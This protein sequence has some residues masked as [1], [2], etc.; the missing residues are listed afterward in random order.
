MEAQKDPNALQEN[1]INFSPETEA[2]IEDISLDL[3][4]LEID[5]GEVLKEI[6]LNNR[7][8]QFMNENEYQSLFEDYINVKKSNIK[9][10]YA[11]PLYFIKKIIYFYNKETFLEPYFL[12]LKS[13]PNQTK[14]KKEK[15]ISFEARNIKDN[16]EACL[17]LDL[18][19]KKFNVMI[20]P[21]NKTFTVFFNVENN[22]INIPIS[23]FDKG[24]NEVTI[25]SSSKKLKFKGAVKIKNLN[26]VEQGKKKKENSFNN[27]SSGDK[28][29]HNESNTNS[30]Q[31]NNSSSKKGDKSSEF[32][33]KENTLISYDGKNNDNLNIIIKENNDNLLLE[34]NKEKIGGE[35][36]ESIANKTF[37]LMCNI[38][39]NRDIKVTTLN[40][41]NPDKINSFFNLNDENQINVFQIDTYIPK[42]SGKEIKKIYERFPNNFLFFEE[43]K[44]NDYTNYEIIGEVSQNIVNNAKQKIAQEFNYIHLINK[45]NNYPQKNDQ[46]FIALCKHFGLNN[47]EKIF[48]LFTD[49]SYI[50]IKFLINLINRNK[51]EIINYFQ[52]KKEK[53]EILT[54][55]NNYFKENE[56]DLLEIDLEKFYNL[57]LF[58]NNLKSNNIKFCTCFIS[59]VIEDKLENRIEEKIKLYMNDDKD[60]DKNLKIKEEKDSKEIKV[61]NN[62]VKKGNKELVTKKEKDSKEFILKMAETIKKN[63]KLR[64]GLTLISNEIKKK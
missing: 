29:I 12:Y 16:K 10:V 52:Q 61:Y 11:N 50:R 25:N 31:L 39:L 46:K 59:D 9:E 60:I 36:F 28:N 21:D 49:G 20:K 13:T 7:Y 4:N 42:I 30:S 14:E 62:N 48:I 3:Q 41:K 2:R 56:F 47:I 64:E 55:L 32:T 18:T 24:K 44:I 6:E 23:N 63:D 57:C 17:S 40:D 15:Y 27:N 38:S 8:E 5:E 58:Y 19:K 1:Q 35:K 22:N 45:F 33:S 37:E 54:E 43:L 34:F 53:K 26:S 51:N